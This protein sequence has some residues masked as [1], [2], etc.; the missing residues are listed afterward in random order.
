MENSSQI[1]IIEDIHQSDEYARY[2]ESIGWTVKKIRSNNDQ[3][4]INVF[5]RKIG[6]LRICKIQRSKYLPDLSDLKKLFKKERILMCKLEPETYESDLNNKLINQYGFKQ[7][8]SPLLGTKTIRV[9]LKP[10]INDVFNSF[11]KDCRYSIRKLANEKMN[12]ELNKFDEF[13]EV[14]RL[15]AKRKNIWIPSKID[16]F[17]LLNAFGAKAFTLTINSQAGAM[18]IVHEKTA[19]YYYAGATKLGT[20]MNL[21]YVVVW[22]A[23][24]LAKNM[25]AVVWDFEGI[26]DQRWPNKGWLGFSH[27]KKSFG[28]EEVEFPG[29]FIKWRWPF[30]S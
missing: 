9:N 3:V 2:M 1:E 24:K 19:F 7:D 20:E 21:P 6:L 15:S 30:S 28:G 27:F 12:L 18:V 8:N 10:E 22:E 23:M 26:Y 11:K 25:G 29:C 14:W 16:Y 4:Y 17:K 5:I 13:Y